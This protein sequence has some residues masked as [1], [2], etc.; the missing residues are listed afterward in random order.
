MCQTYLQGRFILNPVTN[1]IKL[2]FNQAQ[3]L[4]PPE[5]R[6]TSNTV[7]FR[8]VLAVGRIHFARTLLFISV[9]TT[10]IAKYVFEFGFFF[11]QAAQR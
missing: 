2:Q 4:G 5:S 8:T 7:Q 3:F 6:I 9:A 11:R 10:A 1:K